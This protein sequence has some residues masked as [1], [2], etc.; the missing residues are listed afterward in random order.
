MGS[1]KD[2]KVLIVDD[3]EYLREAMRDIFN[4]TGCKIIEAENGTDAFSLVLREKPDL[5]VSDVRMP[6]GD[7][8]ELAKNIHAMT[9]NRPKFIICSGYNDL[10]AKAATDLG[11]LKMFEKPFDTEEL[12]KFAEDLF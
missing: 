6:G 3:D 11:I 10:T 8:I 7:G 2:R 5:V 1:L 12:V 4:F 9:E